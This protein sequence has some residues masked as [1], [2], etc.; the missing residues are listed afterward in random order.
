LGVAELAGDKPDLRPDLQRS[1]TVAPWLSAL[2]EAS[3]RRTAANQDFVWLREDNDRIKARLTDPVASLNEKQ[4][5]EEKAEDD[6]RAKARKKERSSR[7]SPG[8]TQYEITLK[9]ADQPGLPKPLSAAA[10]A[11]D[12]DNNTESPDLASAG[13]DLASDSILGET[14]NILLDYIRLLSAPANPVLA[15]HLP[16]QNA[17]N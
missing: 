6:A 9:N 14:Q 4:R 13:K 5:R 16:E 11:D 8:E 7:Q 3:A 17:S 15:R 2:R 1:A 12:S 10:Q